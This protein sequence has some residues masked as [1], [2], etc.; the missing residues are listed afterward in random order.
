VIGTI[1]AD[2][3][4]T[5]ANG[6][7]RHYCQDS[8]GSTRRLRD[9]N[10]ASLAYYEYEPYGGEYTKYGTDGTRYEFTGKEW[11]AT[12]QLY[13]FPFRY[14]APSVAR[15]ITRD[16]LV[17][18]EGPNPYWYVRANPATMY[19]PDGQLVWIIIIVVGAAI[20]AGSGCGRPDPGPRIPTPP[21][22]L[23]PYFLPPGVG[24]AVGVAN[25]AIPQDI[26][27]RQRRGEVYDGL[28][29]DPTNAPIPP[30][31]VGHRSNPTR[32]AIALRFAVTPD[33]V[34]RN[35]KVMGAAPVR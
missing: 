31:V 13:Y 27:N 32:A 26:L 29:E 19:D 35:G 28:V 2:V 1:L 12:A 20:A 15:W 34:R 5:D 18:V 17:M 33:M 4:G 7:W 3:S 14:Y 24:E 23:P 21:E 30:S 10:K 9:G 11:D 16:P 22:V 8:I 6:T 25:P